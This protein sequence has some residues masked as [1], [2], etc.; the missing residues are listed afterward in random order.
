MRAAVGLQ[1]E[2]DDVDQ[3]HHLEIRRQQVRGRADDRTELLGLLPGQHPHLE[4]AIGGHF[5]VERRSKAFLEAGRD[6]RK[7]EVEPRFTGFHV[8]SGHR[9][10]VVAEHHSAQH[11]QSGVSAHEQSAP[12]VVEGALD[13]RTDGRKRIVGIRHQP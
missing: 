1:V 9:H 12:V 10:C 5:C 2:P 3:P 4:G 13:C 8:A 6:G 7:V 11:V